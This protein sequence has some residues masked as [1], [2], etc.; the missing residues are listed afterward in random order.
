MHILHPNIVSKGA[1]EIRCN[2]AGVFMGRLLLAFSNRLQ[3]RTNSCLN[4]WND[5]Y[6]LLLRL[7][8]SN[9]GQVFAGSDHHTLNF[10][11]PYS[12]RKGLAQGLPNR[13]FFE[14]WVTGMTRT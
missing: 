9:L 6:N 1:N 14:H 2:I 12:S 13:R 10:N 3:V 4:T 11:P 7:T 8:G 5:K